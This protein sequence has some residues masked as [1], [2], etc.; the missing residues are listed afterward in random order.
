MTL[1]VTNR[2]ISVYIGSTLLLLACSVYF[3][4]IHW[5]GSQHLHTVLEILATTLALMV[6][7]MALIRYYSKKSTTI[8][9]I[10]AAFLGTFLLDGYHAIVTSEWF[11]SL[12]PHSSPS[13][14]AWSWSASRVFLALLMFFSWWG[15]KLEERHGK[16][17]RVPE[18]SVFLFVALLTGLDFLLFTTLSLPR[19]YYPDSF[20]GRPGEYIS[21]IF[22]GIALIGYL[23]KGDWK[24][25]QFEHWIV[26]ALLVSVIDQATFIP[27]SHRPYDTMFGLAHLLKMLG[28]V[29][30]LTGLFISMYKLFIRAEKT[31][32]DLRDINRALQISETKYRQI[33][34]ESV[35]TIYTADVYG[36]FTYVNPSGEQLTGYKEAELLRRHFTEVVREDY[37]TKVQEFYLQQF[38]EK[39]E[40]TFFEFPIVTKSG[41]EKWVEQHVRILMDGDRI[42]GFQSIVNDISDRKLYQSQLQ[43]QSK[44]LESAANAIIITNSNGII[45]W[46][47]PAFTTLTGYDGEFAIGKTPKIL[48]SGK[49]NKSFYRQ[50]WETILNNQVWHGQIQNKKK[51]GELYTEEM[52]ITPVTNSDG[53]IQ[54]FIA[55][56]QDISD[57]IKSETKIL[58]S[59]RAQKALNDILQLS[60]QPIKLNDLL[61]SALDYILLLDWLPFQQKGAIFLTDESRGHLELVIAYQLPAGFVDACARIALNSC[62]C[63]K[64]IGAQLVFHKKSKD[65]LASNDGMDH[66]GHYVVPF[67]SNQNILGFLLLY[68]KPDQIAKPDDIRYLESISSILTGL[69][70]R[71]RVEDELVIS[72]INAEEASRTK[73]QF[74][75][76]MSHELRTPLN[77]IIGFSNVL[78]K[79]LK[80]TL[81]SQDLN[82]LGR[83]LD[84]GKHLLELINDILDISKIEAQQMQ[85]ESLVFDLG[86]LISD[87]VT[88]MEIQA[89]NKHIELATVYPETDLTLKGD[90]AKLK[91]V[92][93]NLVSNAIK[94]TDKGSVTI[95]VS[96]DEPSGL[97]GCISVQDSGMGIPADR[98][99][100]IFKEFQQV[101]SST[102][103]RFGGTG[104]GLAISYALCEL[105][106][107][108]LTV[109]SSP[110]QGS[111]F[112]IHLNP[113]GSMDS[114]NRDPQQ[115]DSGDLL[116]DHLSVLQET[117]VLLIE[118][119]PDARE[120][121]R[122]YLRGLGV[123]LKEASSG[124]AGIA[125]LHASTPDAIILD[126]KLPDLPAESVFQQI[127]TSTDV[128]VIIVSADP[129]AFFPHQ[130]GNVVILKKPVS[131]DRFLEVLSKAL[132][133]SD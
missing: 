20:I 71:K 75:A 44:V 8:L 17:Q 58:H 132:E 9:F 2:R 16:A 133:K 113:G 59:L 130:T 105:M 112:I 27:L 3:R 64:S 125:A 47:N 81:N 83:I 18:F 49:H 95:T 77:S 126:L 90:P 66:H 32:H 53:K 42:L 43:L 39:K 116:P 70:Q 41:E 35:G 23:S 37:R 110:G 38:G 107:F 88:Q 91:Q 93:M 122:E 52:T 13:I 7:I 76:T 100:N 25:Q 55:I 22:F 61:K 108:S 62:V 45:Q 120:L 123:N 124:S 65:Q 115:S 106:G 87:I 104:L 73:S 63:G 129:D 54:N 102:S 12:Y 72:K 10:G 84:N 26:L 89:K 33:I 97:P 117:T 14:I 56:K 94:F 11:I 34:E 6:G 29:F 5:V 15:W 4:G 86:E 40:D 50:L 119:D 31:T 19:A 28:Y 46:T 57:R 21:A 128:P 30:V 114:G 69:I 101:D 99:G 60:Q 79:K 36:Y 85:M 74:L 48:H 92:I 82:Y 67:V 78:L 24:T 1:S 98:I 51:S 68:I 96:M 80:T 127:R 121:I 109:E 118:D 131:K 103:R 111:T